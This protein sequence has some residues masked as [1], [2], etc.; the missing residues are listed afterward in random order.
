LTIDMVKEKILNNFL[1]S[2]KIKR[3]NVIKI[4]NLN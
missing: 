4:Y 3:N 1:Q 2:F